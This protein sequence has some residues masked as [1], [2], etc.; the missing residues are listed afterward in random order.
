MHKVSGAF[1][2]TPILDTVSGWPVTA[3][4]QTP[5]RLNSPVYDSVSG[6][7]FVGDAGGYLHQFAVV[8]PG[9]V[10]TSGR[11][12]TNTVNVFDSPIV[13]STTELVY[14]FIGYSG[15]PGNNNPSYINRFDAGTAVASYGTGVQFGNGVSGHATNPA[16][17]IMRSGGFDYQ[18]TLS[19]GA[20]GHIY[21]CVNGHVY[22]VT[23]SGSATPPTPVAFNTPVSNLATC[24]SVTEFQGVKLATTLSTAI[25]TTGA[26][27]VTVA[28]T[29]GMAVGDYVQIDSEVM[30]VATVPASGVTFTVASGGRGKAG[31]TAAT[32]LA[33]GV[34]VEDIRD[35]IFFS[36]SGYANV[37]PCTGTSTS[38]C[39]YAYNVISGAASGTPTAGLAETG[40]TSGIIIDNQSTTQAGAQ[41]VYFS[42]LTGHTAVQASQA[43]LN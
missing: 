41:Q 18:Y 1:N 26:V 25:G 37:S 27:T 5:P 32:H 31:T 19:N 40:G 20:S 29:T 6:N 33:T 39:V 14:T 2:G 17:S 9:T 8:G 16:T 13:D 30:L 35:G 7:I 42:T 3:S 38:G 23:V 34:P 10:H 28:S 15:D 36:V 24:S 4:T 21:T 22:Q 43:G 11:L 12:E